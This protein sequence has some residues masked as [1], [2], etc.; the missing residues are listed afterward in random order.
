M[1]TSMM[2]TGV[3]KQALF[4][5]QPAVTQHGPSTNITSPMDSEASKAF[6][7]SK[8]K[9]ETGPGARGIGDVSIQDGYK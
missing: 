8:S 9:K 4:Y 7:F 2:N 1:A 6:G 5:P 3:N